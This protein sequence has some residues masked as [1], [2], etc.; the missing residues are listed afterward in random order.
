MADVTKLSECA[1]QIVTY[2]GCAKSSYM[3]ALQEAKK[4]NWELVEPRIKEGEQFYRQA[5]E[6]HGEV[7]LEEVNTLEPQITLLM[8][9]AEDQIMSAELVRV[10]VEE[11]IE[12]YTNCKNEKGE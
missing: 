5:H 4:G 9:H 2:A 8:S 1:M 11:L 6:G 12:I 10:L 3:Q 7:L